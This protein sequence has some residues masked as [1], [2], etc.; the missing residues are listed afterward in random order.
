MDCKLN[1]A[2]LTNDVSVARL[3][4]AAS[5]RKNNR[6]KKEM[7]NKCLLLI[8]IIII[9]QKSELKVWKLL[10]NCYFGKIF[11]QT[12]AFGLWQ[13]VALTGFLDMTADNQKEF[14]NIAICF[15]YFE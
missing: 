1:T 11:M 12:R 4:V 3:F 13:R 6:D 14:L 5:E 7:N 15:L 8:C 9:L 2:F 10:L